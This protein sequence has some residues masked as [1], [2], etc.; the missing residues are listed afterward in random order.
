MNRKLRSKTGKDKWLTLSSLSLPK[1]P[2]YG[3]L[4]STIV[5][6]NGKEILIIIKGLNHYLKEIWNYNICNDNYTKLIAE[7]S[8]IN[9]MISSEAVSLNENKSFLYLFGWNRKIIKL[10][11]KTK[12]F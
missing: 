7:E 11:L 5:T 3:G 2:T 9:E 1:D 6:L 10:N 12:Q 4:I 8:V